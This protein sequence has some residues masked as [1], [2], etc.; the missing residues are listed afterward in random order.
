MR[1]D[2]GDAALVGERLA[3]QALPVGEVRYIS[4]TPEKHRAATRTA[5]GPP[6]RCAS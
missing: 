3:S 2:A 5:A 4:D 1:R 6:I